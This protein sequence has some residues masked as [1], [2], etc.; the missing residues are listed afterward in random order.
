MTR[1]L[2]LH[3]E[4]DYGISNIINEKNHIVGNTR[5]SWGREDPKS[6]RMDGKKRKKCI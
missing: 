2:R 5:E 3:S 4:R 1:R 6:S